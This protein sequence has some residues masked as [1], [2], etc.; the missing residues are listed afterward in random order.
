MLPKLINSNFTFDPDNQRILNNPVRFIVFISLLMFCPAVDG[1][2]GRLY[3]QET[4]EFLEKGSFANSLYNDGPY[5]FY[6]GDSLEVLWVCDSDVQQKMII[7]KDTLFA[8]KRCGLSI[9]PAIVD[10]KDSTDNVNIFSQVSKIAAISDIHGQYELFLR[11]LKAHA[12]IDDQRRWSWGNG[13]LVI[14]GDIFDRGP[15]VTETLWFLYQ[16]EDQARSA[17]G[18]VHILLGNHERMVLIGDLRYIHPKYEFVS[19][20]LDVNYDQLYSNNTVLGRWLRAKPVVIKI[21]DL[22]FVHGGLHPN[23]LELELNIEEV[24]DIFGQS[25]DI[26]KDIISKDELLSFLYKRKG[27]LWY[28]GYFSDKTEELHIETLLEEYGVNHIVVGHTSNEKIASYHN[29]RVF[30][31]DASMKNGLNGEV[32]IWENGQFFRGACSGKRTPLK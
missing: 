24:N 1:E 13:H 4:E 17:G 3:G 21:N 12:I 9:E 15:M 22:I 28:R 29:G 20:M 10:S 2:A 19:K 32:L 7:N 18:Y 11:L 25:F 16:L 14:V 30:G 8:P 27:P 26:G 31:I 6:H 5:V 23:F